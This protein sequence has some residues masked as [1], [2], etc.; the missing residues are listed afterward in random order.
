MLQKV[1]KGQILASDQCNG[2]SNTRIAKFSY[3][4]EFFK[5]RN[6]LVPVPLTLAKYNQAGNGKECKEVGAPNSGF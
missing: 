5:L 2:V 4:I 1:N 3:M 6:S